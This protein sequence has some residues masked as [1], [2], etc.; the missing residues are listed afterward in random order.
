MKSVPEKFEDLSQDEIMFFAKIG[1]N[2][3]QSYKQCFERVM[4]PTHINSVIQ[5]ISDE[6]KR[7][8][9]EIN[10]NTQRIIDSLNNSVK[11]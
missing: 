5:P 4:D 1:F 6:Q 3:Y 7:F 9:Q 8:M 10:A 2:F 11:L